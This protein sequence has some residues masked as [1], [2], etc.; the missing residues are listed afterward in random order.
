MWC[1]C[2]IGPF[3]SFQT[4]ERLF[5]FLSDLVWEDEQNVRHKNKWYPHPSAQNDSAN[6]VGSQT[7]DVHLKKFTCNVCNYS[8]NRL[9]NY[10]RHMRRHTGQMFT[11][12]V[13]GVLYNCRYGLQKHIKQKHGVTKEEHWKI[14][15]MK[16]FE[17]SLYWQKM[18]IQI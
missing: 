6:I 11:C 10:K 1:E 3:Q 14:S 17:A 15:V 18:W 9:D 2:P 7:S 12:G 8:V 5:V 4:Q 16:V 13:C